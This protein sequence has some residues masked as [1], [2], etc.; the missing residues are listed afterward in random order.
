MGKDTIFKVIVFALVFS[1][2][3]YGVTSPLMPLE[4]VRRTAGQFVPFFFM[5]LFLYYILYVV[6]L[7]KQIKQS[8]EEMK[9]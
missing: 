1:F 6:D 2:I 3:M 8:I 7:L 9:K 5:F 4:I